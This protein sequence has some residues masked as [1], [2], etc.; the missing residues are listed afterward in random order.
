[1]FNLFKKNE[2]LEIGSPI[3]GKSIQLEDVNDS[4]F[5]QKMLGDGIAIIPEGNTF[6]SPCDGVISAFFPSLHAF[7]ITTEDGTEILVHI[8][9]ETVNENGKGFTSTMSQGAIVKKGDVIVTADMDYLK[10]KYDMTTMVVVTNTKDKKIQNRNVN[11]TVNA[12]DT[13]F[14][15]K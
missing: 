11:Q 6:S 14:I 1:M 3:K 4:M 5:S 13:L 8:G 9:L 15:L 7:G 12:E 10:S 2:V